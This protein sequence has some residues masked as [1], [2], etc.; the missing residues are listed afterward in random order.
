MVILPKPVFFEMSQGT[1]SIN[2]HSK[3]VISPHCNN[4]TLDDAEFFIE[5]IQ[6]HTMLSLP[7]IKGQSNEKNK[8][9]LRKKPSLGLEEYELDISDGIVISGG[10]EIGIHYGMMTL[11]QIVKYHGPVL[12]QLKIKDKPAIDHRGVYYDCAR[13]K[14]SKVETLENLIDLLSEYKVNELQIY[15][16]HSYLFEGLSEAFRDKDALS[17]QDMMRL[18]AYAHKRH[19]ELIPSI[20]TFGHMYE[21]LRTRTFAELSEKNIDFDEPYSWVNRMA[22]HTLDVSNPKSLDLARSMIEQFIPLFRSKKFNICADET[23]DLGAFKNKE[24]AEKEGV[25]AL[26]V[27]FLKELIDIVQKNDREVMFWGDI[28][29]KHPDLLK[30]IPEDVTC[31]NW[32]YFANE[33][34]KNTEIISKSGIDQYVCPSTTGWNRMINWYDNSSENI[35]RMISHAHKHKAKGILNTDWG[36]YGHVNLLGSSLPML[37]YGA[38]LSWNNDDAQDDIIDDEKISISLYGKENS[39]LM[40]LL[41]RISRN[42]I[43]NWSFINFHLEKDYGSQ[44]VIEPYI[45]IM[46]NLDP[47]EIK[48]CVERLKDLKI[49][50]LSYGKTL[51]QEFYCDF[52][53]FIVMSDLMSLTQES[54]LYM[55]HYD[56]EVNHDIFTRKSQ[57]IAVDIEYAVEQYKKVWRLRNRESELN[58][59]TD[60]F[61]KIADKLRQY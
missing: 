55:Q 8:I 52:N 14:V 4:S 27:S 41:R 10:S 54:F 38:A 33:S 22:H 37:V 28:I 34:E 42:Q 24:K 5:K 15:I 3:I 29:L 60:S 21:I 51:S 16:E 7:I 39:K 45:E 48:A 2:N 25:G 50:L 11:L 59:V 6:H 61:Y 1:F 19:I 17:A 20:A 35:R 53:E 18:D 9:E 46:R 31:L 13:G 30:D 58:R 23:F 36:D 32:G 40:N 44:N 26:Y 43:A 49:E 12:P 56:M 47:I 57:E